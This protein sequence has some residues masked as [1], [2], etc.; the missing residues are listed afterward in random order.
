[1]TPE[2]RQPTRREALIAELDDAAMFCRTVSTLHKRAGTYAWS[3]RFDVIAE[4]LRDAA[5]LLRDE[6]AYDCQRDA[7]TGGSCK[8][9][10]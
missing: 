4:T 5:S 3:E 2:T 1:M 10:I 9:I 7:D 8:T 6:G